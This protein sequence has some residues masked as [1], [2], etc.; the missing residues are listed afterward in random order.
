MMELLW[1]NPCPAKC[2]RGM[3]SSDCMYGT[4]IVGQ[5]AQAMLYAVA[6]RF[7]LR[8]G[9]QCIAGIHYNFFP[10]L[11]P[12][13]AGVQEQAGDFTRSAQDFQSER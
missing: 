2:P 3:P 8:Q 11:A 1:T 5:F 13:W 4:S 10:G 6:W 12:L 9:M 7:V